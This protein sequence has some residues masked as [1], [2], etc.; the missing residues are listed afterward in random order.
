MSFN[1]L[2]RNIA[3]DSNHLINM[4][5]VLKWHLIYIFDHFDSQPPASRVPLILNICTVT[6]VKAEQL[7]AYA[8]S[9]LGVCILTHVNVCCTYTY[10]DTNA[11][12]L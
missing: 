12:I 2:I 9:W 10:T 8:G 5:K 7:P 4:N 3:V 6:A 1:K 11:Y